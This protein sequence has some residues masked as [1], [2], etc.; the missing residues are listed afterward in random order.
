VSANLQ[1]GAADLHGAAP[2]IRIS[3]E[4]LGD[5]AFQ[6]AHNVRCAY[7]VGAMY[8]AISSRTMIT[9]LA[10]NGILGFFGSGGLSLQ[11]IEDNTHALAESC[12]ER[13]PY[14]MNLLSTPNDP[15]RERQ[16]VDHYLHANISTVEASAY[17]GITPALVKY[18]VRGLR[19]SSAGEINAPH[20][21]IAKLSRPEV[22]RHFMAPPPA[23]ILIHLY[24]QRELT[25]Q[26]IDLAP[27]I[28]MAQD[29]C[30]EADSAGH[31]DRGVAMALYPV[32]AQLAQDATRR[33]GYRERIRVGCAGG[34]GTPEA[35]AASFMLGADF[36]V[37][38]SVN[39]CTIESGASVAMKEV[40]EELSLHDT[41]HVPAGDLFELGA[42][43]QVVRRGC[44]FPAR[45]I[46]LV[47]LFQRHDSFEDLAA[48]LRETIETQWFKRSIDAIW[49]EILEYRQRRHPDTDTL[50]QPTP[51][52]RTIM[53]LRWYFAETCRLAMAGERARRADFQ[54]HCGPAMGAFNAW[55][56]GTS[57][58]RWF[59]RPVVEIAHRLMQQGADCATRRLRTWSGQN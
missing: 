21:V 33:Y 18:R 28:P 24:D 1:R 29:I 25:Q 6:S 4:A 20:R 17:T 56:R 49:Q 7:V 45:A 50:L 59:Q 35:V 51:R 9:Q 11:E 19:V 8:R 42:K 22:A 43:V 47:D 3:P 16:I 15:G 39:Q 40:L 14:G 57:M 34:I 27:R 37:T 46:Q 2:Q 38:G 13:A 32:I 23:D 36:I 31:T 54:I 10:R 26:E 12:G 41:V 55:V 5:P 48:P 52:Q 58:E 44:L 30:V 53:I